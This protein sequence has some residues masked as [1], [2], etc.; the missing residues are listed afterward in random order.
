MYLLPGELHS[1][2]ADDARQPA[3]VQSVQ[4]VLSGG[5]GEL[6]PTAHPTHAQMAWPAR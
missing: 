4:V 5:G 1:H 3:P 6:V 2:G